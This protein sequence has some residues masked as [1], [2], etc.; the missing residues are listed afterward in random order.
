MNIGQIMSQRLPSVYGAIQGMSNGFYRSYVKNHLTEGEGILRRLNG[1]GKRLGLT[2]E[3]AYN[4]NGAYKAVNIK[5]ELDME[6]VLKGSF[7]ND[8]GSI[9]KTRTALAAVGATLGTAAAARVGMNMV[10]GNY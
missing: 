6:Q 5:G 8:N 9:N 2:A 4:A 3:A 1:R 10:E 7:L